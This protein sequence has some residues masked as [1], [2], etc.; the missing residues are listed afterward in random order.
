MLNSLLLP[1]SQQRGKRLRGCVATAWHD[2]GQPRDVAF[3]KRKKT[4]S[5]LHKMASIYAC[6]VVTTSMARLPHALQNATLEK[7]RKGVAGRFIT[8]P[9]VNF[10]LTWD[11]QLHH[12]T[13]CSENDWQ[14]S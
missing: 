2:C 13:Y 12:A 5:N 14:L 4:R 3:E 9:H 7:S 6:C 11:I 10:R 8:P 1:G